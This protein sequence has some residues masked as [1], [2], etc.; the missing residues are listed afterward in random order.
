[1]VKIKDRNSNFEL[2]RIVSMIFII[3]GHIIMQGNMITNCTNQSIKLILRFLE[4]IVLV[5]VNSFVILSGYF[6]SKSNFRLSKFLALLLQVIFYSTL[7]LIVGEKIGLVTNLTIVDYVESLSLSSVDGYWFMKA[8][9]VVYLLSDIINKF[10]NSLDRKSYKQT[11]I[12]L[13][14]IFSISSYLTGDKFFENNGY[15]FY[16]FIF[17]FFIHS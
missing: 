16:N 3:L 11:L 5:H 17:I 1:M 2:M 9:I 14:I 6:Q 10:I 12:V 7:I 15:N 4:Y 13:F 8:Y